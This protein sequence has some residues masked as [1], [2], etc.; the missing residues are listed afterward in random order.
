[1]PKIEKK[2]TKKLTRNGVSYEVSY[3][4]DGLGGDYCGYSLSLCLGVSSWVSLLLGC[5]L[6]CRFLPG[7]YYS[8]PARSIGAWVRYSSILKNKEVSYD[9]TI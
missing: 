8:A 4:T 2:L 3:C 9:R 7:P 5:Q 6:G 1:M